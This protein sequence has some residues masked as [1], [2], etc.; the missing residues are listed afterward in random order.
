M[1]KPLCELKKTLKR[2]LELYVQLVKNPTHV[3]KKC[4]RAS[5][6]KSLL[7]RPVKIK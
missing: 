7:C 6:E 5:N 1:S 4:G 3:C 2:D